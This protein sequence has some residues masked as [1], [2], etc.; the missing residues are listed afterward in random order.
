M[1]TLVLACVA[2]L[3][4]FAQGSLVEGKKDSPVRVI[5]YEDLQCPDCADF[6]VMLDQ[7]LL[8]KYG[9][10]VAFIHRD[11]PL[12]KHAWARPAAIAS[13]YIQGV[14]EEKASQFRRETMAAQKTIKA[15]VFRD[16]L[17]AFCARN[18]LDAAKAIAALADPSMAAL[19]QSDFE[20]G[21]ARGIARTP[22]ALVNGEPFIET[23]T[24]EQISAG[25]DAA[26]K[27]NGVQ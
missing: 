19:V 15:E 24:V 21:V 27:E 22:T 20:D 12:A 26:L 1:R 5:I 13:R 3:S 2:A 17:R 8:P 6:R 16:W 10:K 11:F 23:F 4:A 7:K 9:A 25:I 18:G 14:S